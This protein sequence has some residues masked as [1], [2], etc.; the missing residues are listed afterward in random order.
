MHIIIPF[1]QACFVGGHVRRLIEV[2]NVVEADVVHIIS[3]PGVSD[4][5]KLLSRVDLDVIESFADRL[6]DLKIGESLLLPIEEALI[7]GAN[8][9]RNH[10]AA[11][12]LWLDLIVLFA[13]IRVVLTLEVGVVNDDPCR[14]SELLLPRR[15]IKSV[16]TVVDG[17]CR[18]VSGCVCRFFYWQVVGEARHE[19]IIAKLIDAGDDSVS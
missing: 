6:W 2:Q 3:V 14:L 18:V 7:G 19:N 4:P 1:E 16:G 12:L 15:L 11:H 5:L 8:G 10:D 9:V 17:R 13:T